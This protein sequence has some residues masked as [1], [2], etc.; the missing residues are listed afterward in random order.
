[1]HGLNF[2]GLSGSFFGGLGGGIGAVIGEKKDSKMLQQ[3][4]SYHN[5]KISEIVL[6][7]FKKNIEQKKLFKI[8]D[9]GSVKLKLKIILYGFSRAGAFGYGEAKPNVNITA[10][11]IS[12]GANTIWRKYDY[13]G[14]S[15]VTVYKFPELLEKPDLVTRSLSEASDV[16]VD[17]LLSNLKSVSTK[18]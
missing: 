13:S 1:M 11:L 14:S 18:Q 9:N 16:V 15:G 7:S 4:L 5:I 6:N 2:K 10:T 12:E 3:Y 8:Q 17:K